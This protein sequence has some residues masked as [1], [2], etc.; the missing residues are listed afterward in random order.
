M[1]QIN[2]VTAQNVILK[3][4]LA[5]IGDRFVASLLDFLI[6][7]GMSIGVL[8]FMGA[9]QNND[10]FIYFCVFLLSLIW[11]FYSLLFEFFLRGQTPG[12]LIMK[13]RVARLDGSPLTFGSLL[14]RWLLR[15]VDFYV[16]MLGIVTIIS[17]EKHQRIGDMAASTI[18]I[19]TR[20]RVNL[21]ETLYKQVEP[22]YVPEF[23][24][25]Y[26]LTAHEMEVIQDVFYQ[27]RRNDK[28]PLVTL[29][30]AK[31][32]ALLQVET[33]LDDLTFLKTVLKDYN[34]VAA[35]DGNRF[36]SKEDF[37]FSL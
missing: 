12:K 11:M 25:A 35:N 8:G 5:N 20:E 3:I 24:T 23:P 1:S 13:I 27:Y 37:S 29:T 6:K 22:G 19:S 33:N 26:R 32:K 2:I 4:E 30:A 28:Y 31:V 10:F 34:V 7:I 16:G 9:A 36:E 17:T 21:A 15:L 14:L 18:V